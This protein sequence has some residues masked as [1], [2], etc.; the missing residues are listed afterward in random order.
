MK[1]AAD[2]LERVGLA[3]RE[4]Y[5]P[6]HL[7]GGQTQSVAIARALI[8]SPPIIIADEPTGNLDSGSSRLIMELLSEIHKGGTTILLVTHNPEIT[9]YANRVVYM[10]DGV[11]I[12]D[13]TTKLGEVAPTARRE[14]YH[15]PGKTMEDDLAGVSVLMKAIP[16]GDKL[17][18]TKR[19]KH[20]KTK[21]PKIGKRRTTPARSQR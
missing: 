14:L 13:E 9:R 10:H 1:T 12:H 16:G 2:M 3:E 4:Y 21:R 15:L 17:Q 18:P 6:K 5:M 11:I 20:A 7:S 19:S 8:N